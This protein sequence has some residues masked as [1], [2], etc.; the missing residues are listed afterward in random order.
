M[1]LTFLVL[2]AA[3]VFA[4]NYAMAGT[5]S[6][7]KQEDPVYKAKRHVFALSNELN[8]QTDYLSSHVQPEN[9]KATEAKFSKT[10]EK[11]FAA[12][13]ERV[14]IVNKRLEELLRKS[15]ATTDDKKRSEIQNSIN[16]LYNDLYL[17]A[18]PIENQ[19]AINGLAVRY[20]EIK[21]TIYAYNEENKR[22]EALVKSR[23][24]T[25]L[26]RAAAIGLRINSSGGTGVLSSSRVR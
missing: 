5:S 6:G 4:G 3:M 22:I 16:E 9:I 23:M 26:K 24:D 13:T 7:L 15:Q 8:N 10:A 25:I 17:I 18:T 14:E 21:K 11:L 20:P 2:V 12:K 1:K 19:S